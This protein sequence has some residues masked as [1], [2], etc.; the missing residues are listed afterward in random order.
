MF[1]EINYLP[2]DLQLSV[3]TARTVYTNSWGSTYSS[4]SSVGAL[5]ETV[6]ETVIKYKNPLVMTL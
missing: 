2:V 6:I 5:V 4:G 1:L 3:I